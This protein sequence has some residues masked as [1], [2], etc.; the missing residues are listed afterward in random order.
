[1]VLTVLALD[2]RVAESATVG[3]PMGAWGT[4]VF[5][6]DGAGDLLADLRHAEP[7]RRPGIVREALQFAVDAGDYLEVIEGQA[8]VAAAA[9]VAAARGDGDGLYGG[10]P[11]GGSVELAR[12]ALDRVV[13]EASEWRELWEETPDLDGAL[14]AVATVRAALV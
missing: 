8:A 12:Q 10:P 4:G 2:E 5:D 14:A 1:M 3:P 6:N 11:D 13:G 9:M 7:A